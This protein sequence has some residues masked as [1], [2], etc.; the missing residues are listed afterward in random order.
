MDSK[1]L[2]NASDRELLEMAA[3]AAGYTVK[4]GENDYSY[5]TSAG[6][7]NKWNPL[8]DDGDEARLE[9]ALLMCVRWYPHG[10]LVGPAEFNINSV[11]A[12][13]EHYN[14]HDGDKQA[15]RRRAGTRAAAAIGAAK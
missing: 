10:V 6:L 8:I 14:K 2:P 15:A 7:S 11:S 3:L 12:F 9:A 1:I 13:F 4:F 5:T